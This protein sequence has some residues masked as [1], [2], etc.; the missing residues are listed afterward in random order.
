MTPVADDH[1][2][3]GEFS[4]TAALVV[5]LCT[6]HEAHKYWDSRKPIPEHLLRR[7]DSFRLTHDDFCKIFPNL[8]LPKATS[9]Y[10]DHGTLKF[11][12]YSEILRGGGI[13]HFVCQFTRQDEPKLFPGCILGSSPRSFIFANMSKDSVW[14]L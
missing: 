12:S 14:D 2:S 1:K 11:R 13:C 7:L 6:F 10:L 8:E 4:H 5:V 3:Q 9:V